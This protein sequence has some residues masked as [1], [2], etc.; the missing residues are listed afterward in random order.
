ME[1]FK[2][3]LKFKKMFKNS[4]NSKILENSPKKQTLKKTPKTFHSQNINDKFTP[5]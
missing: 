4:I 5:K 1:I 3:I 2:T